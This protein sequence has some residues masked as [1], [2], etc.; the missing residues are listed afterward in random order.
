MLSFKLI[1]GSFCNRDCCLLIGKALY[2]ADAAIFDCYLF[3]FTI[4]PRFTLVPRVCF[5]A[6]FKRLASVYMPIPSIVL[7][8]EVE[9][10]RTVIEAYCYYWRYLLGDIPLNT[11]SFISSC[12]LLR[13]LFLL[14]LDLRFVTFD[15]LGDSS[16]T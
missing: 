1:S 4:V 2:D 16:I 11:T 7:V 14:L 5:E 10:L 13:G 15:F 3:Y 9:G 12:D 6:L 8:T